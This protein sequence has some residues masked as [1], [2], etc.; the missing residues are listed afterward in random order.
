MFKKIVAALVIGAALVFSAPA[1]AAV[2]INT[3]SQQELESLPGIGPK[4]AQAIIARR[5]YKSV[6][7]LDEVPGI[8]PKIMEQ[9]RPIVT[10]GGGSPQQQEGKDE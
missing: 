10:V 5:P 8:G 7:E 2:D 6:E 1:Y 3:A 4:K 9:L